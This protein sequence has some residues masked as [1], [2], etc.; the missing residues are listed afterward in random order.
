MHSQDILR[1]VEQN[2]DTF[3]ELRVGCPTGFNPSSRIDFSTLGTNIRE[4]LKVGE[5]FSRLGAAIGQ[6]SNLTTLHIVFN[7]VVALDVKHSAFF[8]GLKHNTSIHQLNIYFQNPYSTHVGGVV[9]ALLEAYQENSNLTE[10]SIHNADLQNGGDRLVATTLRRCSNLKHIDLYRSNITDEQLWP[11]VDAIR[12]HRSLK[13]LNFCG[14]RIGNTG[15]GLLSRLLQNSNCN[16]HTLILDDNSI[17]NDG[18]AALANSLSNNT[19][20]K[21]LSLSGNPF[22]LSVKDIFDKLL[23]NTSSINNIHSSNH[24]LTKLVLELFELPSRINQR[25][26]SLLQLNKGAN[27]SHVAI[28]KI[29]KYHPNIDMEPLFEWNMEGNGERDLKALPYVVAWFERAGE[30]VADD[31]GGEE[32]FNIGERKLS[33]I[34][35]FAQS[36]PLLFVPS[37][38]IISKKMTRKQRRD[39]MGRCACV[40]M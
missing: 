16:L 20:L 19:K 32:S 15:C 40:L 14:N 38:N 9:E 1:R 18:A 24:T 4:K 2:D 10:L 3:T 7:G 34:Y 17:G 39:D 5:D 30:A 23:C 11:M 25:L 13:V 29:L 12:G 22:D 21:K 36:M 26:E 8:D 37:A 28:K 27:K 33:A 6:N 31:E 35:Q